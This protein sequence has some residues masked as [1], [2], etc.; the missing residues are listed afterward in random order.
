MTSVKTHRATDGP[1][2]TM[3]QISVKT[4][5]NTVY[6][7]GMAAHSVNPGSRGGFTRQVQGIQWVENSIIVQP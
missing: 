4:I 1:L 2:K 5:E 7:T 6:L 3:T